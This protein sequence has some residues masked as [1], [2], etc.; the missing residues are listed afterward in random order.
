MVGWEDG[1]I[2]L[3]GIIDGYDDGTADGKIERVGTLDGIW[4][5]TS[6]WDAVG[7]FDGM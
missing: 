3:E 6:G 4:L 1:V 7:K 5:G 2:L